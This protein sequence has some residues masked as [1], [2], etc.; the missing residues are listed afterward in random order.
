M[1]VIAPRRNLIG[2]PRS[3][4]R[5][6][7]S[8]SIARVVSTGGDPLATRFRLARALGASSERAIETESGP[9]EST[10]L[11]DRPP[12][13]TIAPP[14]RSHPLSPSPFSLSLPLFPT[15]TSLL[16]FS[17]SLSAPPPLYISL[18][19]SLPPF[20]PAGP[21]RSLL[22]LSLSRSVYLSISAVGLCLYR[23]PTSNSG[24]SL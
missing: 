17:F 4:R 8:R 5:L 20:D 7:F 2:P 21:R 14:L 1:K 15:S 6:A 24:L 13:S 10:V 3:T 23:I 16:R 19:F 22:S 9:K 18:S 11:R 12:K